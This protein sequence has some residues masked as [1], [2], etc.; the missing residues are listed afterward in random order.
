MSGE[1]CWSGGG[2]VCDWSQL[3]YLLGEDTSSLVGFVENGIECGVLAKWAPHL[4]P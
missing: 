1:R 2:G 4:A 3:A